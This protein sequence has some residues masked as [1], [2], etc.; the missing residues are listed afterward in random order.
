MLI[1]P[2]A[3]VD[4]QQQTEAEALVERGEEVRE[5]EAEDTVRDVENAKD[6][7]P[8]RRT[9]KVQNPYRNTCTNLGNQVLGFVSA[10]KKSCEVLLQLFPE[11]DEAEIISYYQYARGIRRTINGYMN[12]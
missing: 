6:H 2:Y 3:S 10:R 9:I 5:T 7:W 12:I 4:R 1:H 8:S 11:L